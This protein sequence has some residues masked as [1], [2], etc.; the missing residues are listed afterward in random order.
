MKICI[1]ER[2]NFSYFVFILLFLSWKSKIKITYELEFFLSR[3]SKG[4]YKSSFSLY[5]SIS[6]V[7]IFVLMTYENKICF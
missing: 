5:P 6:M 3:F 7:A 1:I 4:L 2:I